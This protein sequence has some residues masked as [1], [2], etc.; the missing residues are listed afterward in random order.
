MDVA[1]FLVQVASLIA[2]IVYVVK[3]AD[4]A[5]ATRDAAKASAAALQEM[6]DTRDAETAPYVIAYFDAYRPPLVRLVVKNTGKSMAHDVQVAMDP[7]LQNSQGFDFGTV[8]F[9]RDGIP[10]L[11]PQQEMQTFVDSVIGYYGRE[12]LPRSYRVTITYTGGL[13]QEQRMSEQ[14]ADIGVFRNALRTT[15]RTVHDLVGET[16]KIHKQVDTLRRSVDALPRALKPTKRRRR[17][18][19]RRR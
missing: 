13:R 8:A 18:S 7:R 4:I 17:R 11:A 14:V 6:R 2:L 9:L 10:A 15:E 5:S 1:L 3:T 16:E 12:E 19:A